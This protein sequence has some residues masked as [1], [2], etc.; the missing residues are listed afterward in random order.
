[1]TMSGDESALQMD[2]DQQT[3]L[4]EAGAEEACLVVGRF[5]LFP[6]SWPD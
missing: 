1:M 3:S 2:P 5:V 4:L 6:E